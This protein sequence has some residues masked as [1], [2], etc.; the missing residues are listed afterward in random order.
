MAR[1]LVRRFGLQA[2]IGAE[3]AANTAWDKADIWRI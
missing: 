2:E 3:D 1:L